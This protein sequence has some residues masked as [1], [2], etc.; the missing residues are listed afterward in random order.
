[1]AAGLLLVT[2]HLDSMMARQVE[3]FDRQLAPTYRY[4]FLPPILGEGP[5]QARRWHDLLFS[6]YR[7]WRY[8]I[9]DA[10]EFGAEVV[11]RVRFVG[12]DPIEP[13]HTPAYFEDT[14][15]MRF[16]I[17]GARLTACNALYLP[18]DAHARDEANAGFS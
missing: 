17:S 1:M 7:H 2:S 16:S 3:D 12:E 8:E 5:I 9:E 15:L 4:E 13:A 18:F 14:S 6:I 10:N 11:V